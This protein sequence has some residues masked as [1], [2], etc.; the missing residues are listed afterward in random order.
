MPRAMTRH[1]A[2]A[3]RQRCRYP[4]QDQ[5]RT[6]FAPGV[7]SDG[8]SSLLACHR[9][10]PESVHRTRTPTMSSGGSP[11]PR[12]ISPTSAGGWQSR[13]RMPRT[14]GVRSSSTH[15][16]PRPLGSVQL[17]TTSSAT[18]GPSLWNLIQRTRSGPSFL[19][20]GP[21]EV[22]AT[23]LSCMHS[24]GS[25]TERRRQRRLRA[26]ARHG[27]DPLVEREA[28]RADRAAGQ[29][30]ARRGAHDA[31]AGN[32]TA[33]RRFGWA[34]RRR[35]GADATAARVARRLCGRRARWSRRRRR[36]RREAVR[37]PRRRSGRGC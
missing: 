26:S 17:A 37:R 32:P 15:S 30:S 24:D 23:R 4:Y 3:G 36:P 12:L 11:V 8:A 33:E 35:C 34:G 10:P 16:S 2:R 28:G 13:A 25:R 29:L 5:L 14:T 20:R 9:F 19:E 21:R 6:A 1:H 27:R 22:N 31:D 18:P 7:S